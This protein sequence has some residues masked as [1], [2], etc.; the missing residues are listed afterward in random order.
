MEGYEGFW[1]S[2]T[3]DHALMFILPT[4]AVLFNHLL[5]YRRSLHLRLPPLLR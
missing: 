3:A 2:V 4:D 5:H 1:N